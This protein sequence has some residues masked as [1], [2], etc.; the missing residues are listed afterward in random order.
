MKPFTLN[1]SVQRY[2]FRLSHNNYAWKKGILPLLFL[3]AC[4]IVSA[5]QQYLKAT[6]NTTVTIEPESFI[7][8]GNIT[9]NSILLDQIPIN[10]DGYINFTFSGLTAHDNV[11]VSL[12]NA[13]ASIYYLMQ[14][15]NNKAALIDNSGTNFLLSTNARNNSLFKIK[16]CG[17]SIIWSDDS[18]IPMLTTSFANT[19]ALFAKVAVTSATN[20]TL[21]LVFDIDTNNEN[22]EKCAAT[23]GKSLFP[24]DL[25]FAGYDNASGGNQMVLKTLSSIPT[26]TSFSLMQGSYTD[27]NNRWYST[28]NTGNIAI[29]KI[30]YTGTNTITTGSTICFTLPTSGTGD[31]LL[32]N[33]FSINSASNTDFC[34][35]NV[36][37][38]VNPQINISSG[39]ASALFLMQ[40]D[41]KLL[42]AHGEFSGR[43][44]SGLQYGGNWQINGASPTGGLSNLPTDID[45]MAIEDGLSPASR[46][47]YYTGA[48]P[49]VATIT[50][51]SN[52]Q[53]GSGNLP[54]SACGEAAL[55][56]ESQSRNSII[57]II[58]NSAQLYPN[59][60]K[61]SFT[62]QLDLGETQQVKIDIYDSSG[63]I[64]KHQT[65]LAMDAGSNQI[66]I[67]FPN[68]AS[69]VVF[70]TRIQL[71]NE[72]IIKRMVKQGAGLN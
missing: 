21:D 71:A 9:T 61:N 22:C 59:P 55:I 3:F 6:L 36:S 46:Y 17:N 65:F 1:F 44:L 25:M 47:A 20:V 4:Q 41:W 57:P 69:D 14:F 11:T 30:T 33:S 35:E 37:N 19:E 27:S 5:Q 29:Q 53:T 67:T 23:G 60:F 34:V 54:S 15:S 13:T 51:F 52:W 26:G 50:E 31:A 48:N 72:I 70:W 8:L 39:T 62:I 40:G 64:V 45:C 38:T 68:G 43:V 18:N 42:D 28:N 12:E 32:A 63:R 56:V 16:K 7:H 10:S 2:P 49:S 24:G 58:Q 66:P